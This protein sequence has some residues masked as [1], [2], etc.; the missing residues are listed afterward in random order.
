MTLS[1]GRVPISSDTT[2]RWNRDVGGSIHL[3]VCSDALGVSTFS[4]VAVT[5]FADKYPSQDSRVSGSIFL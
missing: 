2:S 1:L 4:R 3:A 5:P